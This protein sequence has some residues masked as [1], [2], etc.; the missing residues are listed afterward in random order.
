[1]RT[2]AAAVV[3]LGA[4]LVALGAARA[5]SGPTYQVPACK[6][7]PRIDGLDTAGEWTGASRIALDVPMVS[8]KGEPRPSRRAELR[9]MASSVNLYVA[10]TMPDAERNMST[11]PLV[12]DMAVLAFCRGADVA[13]GDDRRVVLP[14]AWADKHFV[15]PGKDEDDAKRDG[16][17]AMGWRAEPGG[18]RYFIEWQVPLR[19][20][21]SNDIAVSP[22]DRLRFDIAYLDKFSTDLASAQVGG[23]FGADTD[24]V[25]LWA[26]LEL[27]KDVGPEAPAPAPEWLAKLFP[28]TGKPDHLRNRLSRVD[29]AEVDIQ[30]KVGGWATVQFTYPGL[31]GR[32]EVGQ[33]RI[34]LPPQVR[35]KPGSKVSLIHNAGYELDDAGAAALLAKGYAVSTP[36]ADPRNPLGRGVNLDR[37]VL[38]AVRALPC[39]DPGRVSI[40][41]GSAGGWMTL[42]LAADAFPL[43]WAMPDV[44]P[45]HW[46]Y[47]AAYIA[48][49]KEMAGPAPGGTQ[50]RLPVLAVVVPIAEQSLAYYGVPFD[51]PAY[52]AI[53]PLAHLD[54]IT[55]PTLAVFST[56]DI[57]VPLDQVSTPLVQPIDSA[58]F[59]A[60]FT[61]AMSNRFPGVGGKRTLLSALPASRVDVFPVPLPDEWRVPQGG[62]PKP[63]AKPIALPFSQQKV[64]SVVVIDEGPVEPA[65]GHFKYQFGADHEPFRSWAEKRGVTPDQLTQPKLERLMKRVL[66]QPWRPLRVRPGGKG[67]EIAGNQLD[68]REA[69]RADV[70]LGLRAFAKDDACARRLAGVYASLPASLKV[71]GSRLGDGSAAGVRKAL[72]AAATK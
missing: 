61:T 52:L 14:G 21:D 10:L 29:A 65:D 4:A 20:G 53:S 23:L 45:V 19:S 67:P 12:A 34:F 9:L 5:Q 56:A 33:A 72:D 55:A 68:Y 26:T 32:D 57:L 54:T 50:P 7:A 13:A 3:A 46:G 30:G 25:R 37:A 16:A 70:L 31:D 11:S 51:S 39:I 60:G 59:P 66:G 62:Q 40:Q 2:I 49:H 22:G 58:K 43:V 18:G 6:V 63:G 69:E 8:G 1:M 17:A 28:Y 41:G 44:P 64:W 35:E 42:M 47:N 27:P 48:E 71:L 15:A 36:H 38:H 24:H